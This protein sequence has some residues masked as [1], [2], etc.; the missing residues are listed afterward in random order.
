[1]ANSDLVQ[2]LLRGLDLVKLL[3]AHPE[4]AHLNDL[5]EATG[6]KK[7]TV[8]N[9]LRTLCARGFAARD[10]AGRYV[11]GPALTAAADGLVGGD[12]LA[13]TLARAPGE[14]PGREQGNRRRWND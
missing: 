3:A 5:A 4:G 9:L 6:L 11:V 10:D 7:P 12:T 8:H 13:F 1:M 2:S 14:G